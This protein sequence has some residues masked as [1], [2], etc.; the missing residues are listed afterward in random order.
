MLK[1]RLGLEHARIPHGLVYLGRGALSVA[2]GC[3]HFV[4]AGSDLMIAGDYW[5]PHQALSMVLLGPGSM[6][7]TTRCAC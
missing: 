3:L 1:G 4:A 7:A 5:I 6:S 2:D